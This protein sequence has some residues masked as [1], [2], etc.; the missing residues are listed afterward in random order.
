MLVALW[1]VFKAGWS[2]INDQIM[3]DAGRRPVPL[4]LSPE[5]AA[6]YLKAHGRYVPDRFNGAFDNYTRPDRTQYAMETG[7]WGS[8]P[9]DCD[10]WAIWAHE[11]LRQ[12]PGVEPYIVTLRDAGIVGSHVIC[13]YRQGSRYGAIDTNGHR[14]LTDIGP[15]TLCRVWTNLYAARG[16]RYVEA[17]IT[18]YPF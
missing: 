14:F 13:V 8:M 5:A 18:P 11:A 17:A 7:D 2:R 10:D 3:R 1:N 4:L 12:M 15:A 16:Y 6:A 9:C